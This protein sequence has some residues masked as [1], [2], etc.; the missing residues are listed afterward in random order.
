MADNLVNSAGDVLRIEG[1]SPE[2]PRKAQQPAALDTAAY[3]ADSDT[4]KLNE[5]SIGA[6]AVLAE[7]M[8]IETRN[9]ARLQKQFRE[10][11]SRYADVAEKRLPDLMEKFSL[12]RF[13]FLDKTTGLTLIIKLDSGKWRVALPPVNGPTAVP[14]NAKKREAIYAWLREI[15]QGGSLKKTIE[16][17]AGLLDDAKV[18]E[19]VEAIMAQNPALDVATQESIAPATLTALVSKLL[20]AGKN[21]HEAL[22]VREVREAKIAKK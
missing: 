8:I 1:A 22:Q 21:V 7:E 15:G 6:L 3:A 17:Q 9:M 12:P 20:K 10:A 11:E 5:D 16:V 2:P 14:E 4:E 19:V 18:Q 13:E